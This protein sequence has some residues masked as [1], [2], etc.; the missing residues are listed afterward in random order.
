MAFIA[1]L[2]LDVTDP[3]FIEPTRSNFSSS[4]LPKIEY[5]AFEIC[6]FL[7]SYPGSCG[8]SSQG[9]TYGFIQVYCFNRS[10]NSYIQDS[11]VASS[12]EVLI[13]FF[14]LFIVG[15]LGLTIRYFQH[16]ARLEP[17]AFNLPSCRPTFWDLFHWHLKYSTF[18][19]DI[20][21]SSF[22]NN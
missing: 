15:I 11:F 19:L 21:T 6:S 8:Y 2:F 14:D 5:Q 12:E 3:K 9:F 13:M 18:K 17:T 20:L 16:S 7:H 10:S 1:S 4:Y 22:T